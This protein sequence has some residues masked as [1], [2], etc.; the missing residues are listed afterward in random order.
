MDP[1]A[2]MLTQEV[3]R[4]FLVF[5]R[6]AAAIGVLPGFGESAVPVR[7]RLAVALIVT[8]ILL[9]AVPGLPE[10]IP[11]DPVELPALF[12]GEM[13]IGLFLGLGAKLF[14][15]ALQVAGGLAAQ[16][17][18]LGNPFAVDAGGFEG[19]S[20]L[21]GVLLIGG[22]AL[23]FATDV[24]YLMIGALARSYGTWPAG[25]FPETAELARRFAELVAVTFRLGVA[26]ATPFLLF[27]LVVN[28]A[29]GLVNRV[30]PAMPVYFVGTPVLLLVGLTLFMV[31]AGAMLTGFTDAL[32][33]WLDGR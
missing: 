18:G 15:S 32:S 11:D 7:V 14:L 3:F 2:Q 25:V 8:L 16:A 28:V 19:G 29:L 10:R 26:L 5:V 13:L 12:A 27:G 22:L 6:V 9:P 1:L 23:L 33:Q 17:V 20:V 31:T 30:M 24:H 21:S 4:A